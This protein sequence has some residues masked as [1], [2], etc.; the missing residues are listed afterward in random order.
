[1][2]FLF[3]FFLS[4]SSLICFGQLKIDV[5]TGVYQSKQFH[6]IYG[7]V[8]IETDPVES[9]ITSIG[10]RYPIFKNSYMGLDLFYFKGGGKVP[11]PYNEA[12][13]RFSQ[14]SIAP[15]LGYEFK[16]WK[17]FIPL[18]IGLNIGRNFGGKLIKEHPLGHL[19]ITPFQFNFGHK[20]Y[21]Y[22]LLSKVSI[23]YEFE[24]IKN[25]KI[26][27]TYINLRGLSNF[28][29]FRNDKAESYTVTNAG[30]G[31]LLGL[32]YCMFKQKN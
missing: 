26:H 30:S 18:E 12:T 14:V 10:G 13:T 29:E 31:V 28:S 23:G 4:F 9:F 8:K 25:L 22:S 15:L 6:D 7:I 27:L 5:K 17:L 2:K 11:P 24:N 16:V 21:E 20:S 3:A 19:V 32:S 1:M